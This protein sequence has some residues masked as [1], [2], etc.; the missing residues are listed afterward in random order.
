MVG[1]IIKFTKKYGMVTIFLS[2]IVDF[3]FLI[4]NKS[5][6]VN[7]LNSLYVNFSPTCRPKFICFFCIKIDNRFLSKK[8]N[9]IELRK[10]NRIFFVDEIPM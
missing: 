5:N 7:S 1:W 6:L 4:F 9:R 2:A 3:N 8:M 10:N